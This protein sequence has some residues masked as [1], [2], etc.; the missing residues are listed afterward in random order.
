MLKSCIISS[1]FW[2]WLMMHPVEEVSPQLQPIQV[3][4]GPGL[5]AA[6]TLFSLTL[7]LYF[8]KKGGRE[9]KKEKQPPGYVV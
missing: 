4:T 7:P 1:S 8:E 5:L 3:S 6:G 2:I 9:R